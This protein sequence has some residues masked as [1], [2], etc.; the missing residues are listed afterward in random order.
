MDGHLGRN[1]LKGRRGE[2]LVSRIGRDR[3]TNS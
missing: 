1:F 2:P 3:D